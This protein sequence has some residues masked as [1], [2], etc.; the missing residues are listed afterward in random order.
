MNY[1]PFTGE[2]DT[3]IHAQ[4]IDWRLRAPAGEQLEQAIWCLNGPG[5]E[6]GILRKT[7]REVLTSYKI[8]RG[9]GREDPAS[10]A[11]PPRGQRLV[12]SPRHG[13]RPQ[14]SH[15]PCPEADNARFVEGIRPVV[16]SRRRLAAPHSGTDRPLAGR[17]G[18]NYGS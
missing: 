17:L 15:L 5:H 2:L 11:Q 16:D 10:K 7:F 3:T 4:G 18:S 14:S 12:T 1:R 9:G 6:L 13:L 8:E